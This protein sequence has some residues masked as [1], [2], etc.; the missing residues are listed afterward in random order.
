MSRAHASALRRLLTLV[1]LTLAHP[2]AVHLARAT[3]AAPAPRSAAPPAV[4]LTVF[5]AA[6]LTNVLQ[7]V[8]AAYTRASG[9]A[10]TF[11]FAGT[12]VLARQ[13][14]AGARA[15][16]FISA[17]GEWMD[18]AE[19]RGLLEPGTR[20]D[21]LGNRLVLIAPAGSSARL[22]FG[23][24][25][26]AALVAALGPSGRLSLA[27]PDA[28]PAGR[29]ARAALVRLGAWSLVEARLARSDN[30]R[31]ALTFVARGEAPLGIVYATDARAEARVRIVGEFPA[32]SY[33]PIRYPVAALRVRTG[34]ACCSSC[35]RRPRVRCSWPPGST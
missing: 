29:Y 18:Y 31:T 3:E 21:L 12:Q 33:P 28:V 17:D 24:G 8:G 25:F 1:L 10:V 5:A 4:P 6:S 35:A 2:V 34:R 32:G 15:D 20:S 14:E 19:A 22:G 9:Q 16:L 13:L 30:V 7:A 26:P 11:S 27:D 23:T